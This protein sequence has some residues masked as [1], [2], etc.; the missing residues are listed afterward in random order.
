MS[1][2]DPEARAAP[3]PGLGTRLRHLLDLLESDLGTIYAELGL[4]EIRPRFV[5]YLRALER[6]GPASVRALA[7]RVGVTHS[8]AS[9]TVAQL[10]ARGLVDLRPGQ[11][12][13]ERIVHL[14]EHARNLL[15]TLHA[16]WAATEAAAAELEAELGHPLGEVL[17]AAASALAERPFHQRVL[18]SA[19]AR[20]LSIAERHQ[21]DLG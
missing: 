11:D 18:D 10:R 3:D 2:P 16:E 13:R 20:G 6:N 21:Y 7:R 17:A 4:D 14:T 5:G 19:R 9:Q 8:A 15:P 1:A 12:A